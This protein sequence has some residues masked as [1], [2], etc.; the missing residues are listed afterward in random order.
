MN[1]ATHSVVIDGKARFGRCSGFELEEVDGAFLVID[2]KQQRI[3]TLNATATLVFQL[4]DGER[5]FSD[6]LLL[7]R[8]AYPE[9]AAQIE[10]D[11]REAIDS[12]VRHGALV[13]GGQ[14]TSA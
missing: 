6:I 1:R 13:D 8:E 3:L 4:C 7:L 5:T 14:R 12:L 10:G 11:A 9:A 2:M